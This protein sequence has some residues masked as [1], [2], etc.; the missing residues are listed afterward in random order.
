MEGFEMSFGD[1]WM[2][3]IKF[4]IFNARFCVLVMKALTKVMDRAV[5]WRSKRD[6]SFNGYSNVTV[7]PLVG[8][9]FVM[10]RCPS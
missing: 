7:T 9:S 4:C 8:W 6:A 2:R 3:W 10:Q 1:K 5:I